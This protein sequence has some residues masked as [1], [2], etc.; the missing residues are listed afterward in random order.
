MSLSE[1]LIKAI[2]VILAVVGLLVTLASVGISIIG[3]ASISPWWLGL[4]V[5][6]LLLGVGI[7]IIRG[8]NISL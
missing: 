2:G 6:L 5:G 4:I 7:Y 3:A 8:G 1:L